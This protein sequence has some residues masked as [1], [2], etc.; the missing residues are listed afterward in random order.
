MYVERENDK[1]NEKKCKLVV[2]G[3]GHGV[4][5]MRFAPCKVCNHIKIKS[6]KE[7][8]NEYHLSFVFKSDTKENQ[9][10]DH[11]FSILGYASLDTMM[12]GRLTF[13]RKEVSP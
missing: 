2:L 6:Y 7:V 3:K 4:L 12:K 9:G 10:Q 8:R 5:C 13:L 1:A 11:R